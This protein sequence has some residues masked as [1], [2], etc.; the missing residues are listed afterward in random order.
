MPILKAQSQFVCLKKSQITQHCNQSGVFLLTNVFGVYMLQIE[1]N[2]RNYNF[3]KVIYITWVRQIFT[4]YVFLR[5]AR[6]D[7]T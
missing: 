1:V 2:R 3:Y 4:M 7:I 6:I 5:L